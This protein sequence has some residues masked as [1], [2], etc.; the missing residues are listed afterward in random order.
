MYKGIYIAA[1]GAILKQSQLE[2]I[3]QNIAN[4]NT[5]GYKRATIS[6][7]DYLLPKD[8]VASN[9]DGRVMSDFSAVKADFSNGTLIR[10]GNPLDVA[11]EGDGFIAME[12]DRYTRRGDLKKDRDGYLTT[13]NG[14]K[15]LGAGGPIQIP[16]DSLDLSI[17]AEGKVSVMQ[18]GSTLPSELD[19]LMIMDFG[20]DAN[21]TKTGNG[22]YVAGGEGMKS[23]SAIKQGYRE[24]SNVDAVIEMVRM[25]DSMREFE[26]YQKIIQTFD[27][28]TAKVTNDMGRL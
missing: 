1:S 4:A 27:E 3:T 9:P 16:P 15:V 18:P 21:M 19:T 7:K 5:V 11:I 8:V 10:T 25:I 14:A 13:S 12:G 22:D 24:G 26:S 23:S 6:F 28:A 20:P 2:V 17:D